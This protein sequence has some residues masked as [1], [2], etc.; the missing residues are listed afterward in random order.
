MQ[1][2]TS[3]KFDRETFDR[4]KRTVLDISR[5]Q[6]ERDRCAGYAFPRPREV[7][8]QLTHRCNLRCK[9]CFQWDDEG[10]FRAFHKER[11]AA[12]LDVSVIEKLLAATH[13]EKSN[14]YIWGGEPFVHREWDEIARILENDRRW[15]VLSTNGLLMEKKMDS[16]LRLSENMAML[17]S[18]DG[19]QEELD[20]I[21]GKGVYDRL[22]KN[23]ELLLSLQKKGDYKGKV[24]INCVLNDAVVPHLYEF[25][26]FCEGLGGIDTVYFT[27]PY[28]ISEETAKKM[29]KYYQRNLSW[30]NPLPTDQKASWHCYTHHLDSSVVDDLREQMTRL[31]SRTWQIRIRLQP[32]LD[33]H[34]VGDFIRGSELTAQNRKRCY[35]VSNRMDI[36]ADG[37]ICTCKLFPEL[38]IGNLDEGDPI[39]VW[40]SAE[41]IRFREIINNGL[42]PICSQCIFLYLY[43]Q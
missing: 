31:K 21:R 29:D 6:R 4:L 26:E 42:M 30:L 7:G 1:P 33:V 24:T 32:A 41:F 38:A 16:I 10:F 12:E 15:I 36:L 18:L 39:E 14:L 22:M 20:A 2:K 19:F 25:M 13:E 35:A 43:G 5:A 11:Q 23:L 28:Y 27:F 8:I 37:K 3:V 34:E 40:R 17:V 9:H